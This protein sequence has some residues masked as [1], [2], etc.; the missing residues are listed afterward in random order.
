MV[1]KSS[2]AQARNEVNQKVDDKCFRDGKTLRHS[3]KMAEPSG[4]FRGEFV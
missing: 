3:A 4:F 2:L 1:V